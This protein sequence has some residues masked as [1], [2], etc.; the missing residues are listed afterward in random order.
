MSSST[1]DY[2]ATLR[3]ESQRLRRHIGLG[4]SPGMPAPGDPPEC[5][6]LFFIE[7]APHSRNG[8]ACRLPA[9]AERISPGEYR[10]ALNPGM[11]G[12]TWVQASNKNSG[13]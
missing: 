12:P 6:V 3:N 10:L 8:A 9:C 11:S 4:D 7:G 2:E 5:V 13:K 1:P